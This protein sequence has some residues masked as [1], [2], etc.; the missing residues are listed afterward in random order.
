MAKEFLV[1]W[2]KAARDYYEAMT[3][4][5]N[6]EEIISLLTKWSMVKD[7]ALFDKMEW[8]FIHPNGGIMQDSI[9]DQQEWYFKNGYVT[10]KVDVGK[11]IEDGYIVYALG[12]LGIH[13]CDKCPKKRK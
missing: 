2:L 9:A 6:R 7:R 11:M 1:A 3:G 13:P 8:N 5:R 10:Q 12:K 4:G